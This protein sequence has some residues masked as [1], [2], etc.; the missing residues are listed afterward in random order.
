MGQ[1]PETFVH[2]FGL[3]SIWVFFNGA[4]LDVDTGGQ[5]SCINGFIVLREKLQ[6]CGWFP[7][8]LDS[9]NITSSPAVQWTAGLPN[10][11]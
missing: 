3:S 7:A 11:F 9:I 5:S 6:Q 2:A 10:L 1:K 4:I 8:Q